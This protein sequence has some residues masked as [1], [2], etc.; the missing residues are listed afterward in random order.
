MRV[1]LKGIAT[2]RQRL[3]DGTVAVY[4]YAWR[5]GPRIKAEPGSAA[6]LDEYQSALKTRQAPPS[7]QFRALIAAYK[8]SSD[9]L[10]KSDATR[11]EYLRYIKLIEDKYGTLPIAALDE[12][13]M[14][15]EFK[16]WRETFADR[17]RTA[18][19]LWAV[20][21]RILAVAADNEDIARNPCTK[22]ERLYRSAR[23]DAIWTEPMIAAAIGSFPEHLR[24]AM[25]LALWTGQRQGDLLR[26]PWS[27]Y[28][29]KTIRLAQSKTA[30]R[31]QIPVHSV[32]QAEIGRIPKRSPLMLTTSRGRP[33]TRHGFQSSWRTALARAGITGVTFHD[34]RGSAVTR[35][36][37]ASCTA[38]EIGSITGHSL[39]DVEAILD[40]HY[41]SRTN[42]LAENAVRKL[43]RR[44]TSAKRSAKRSG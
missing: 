41:L 16:E 8:G 1:D 29:G 43:E 30:R 14:R 21:S 34:L 27:G 32:L 23:R 7:D 35:L 19:Y 9:F 33:W 13:G 22:G 10:N 39:K 31:V 36:A 18:D 40:S 42:E 17:P 25:M 3:A 28:D 11:R 26:L 12:K 5:G 15:K 2:V 20:L 37:V 24:W 38:A 6:F 44:T 4:R